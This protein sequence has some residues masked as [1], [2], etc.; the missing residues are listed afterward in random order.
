MSGFIRLNGVSSF[1]PPALR[2]A[3]D[4]A[5]KAES[6]AELSA[7][8]RARLRLIYPLRSRRLCGETKKRPEGL[9]IVI[10]YSLIVTRYLSPVAK[11]PL[12]FTQNWFDAKWVNGC[13]EARKQVS[14]KAGRELKG[15]GI[16]Y[17]KVV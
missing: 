6:P 1:S 8:V 12:F 3:Q 10:G 14:W 15:L 11:L 16:N 13:W 7:S 5:L 9:Q 2:E 17:S 4:S